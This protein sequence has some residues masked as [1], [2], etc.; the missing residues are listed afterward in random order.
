MSQN[1]AAEHGGS[2][3]PRI[4]QVLEKHRR[5]AGHDVCLSDFQG[6]AVLVEDLQLQE[7]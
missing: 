7:L 4:L 2:G 5:I 1:I 3:P 6:V